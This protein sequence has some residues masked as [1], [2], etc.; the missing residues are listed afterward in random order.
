MRNAVGRLLCKSFFW[1]GVA[2]TSMVAFGRRF[3]TCC[4]ITDLQG[5]ENG[6]DE[7]GE[8]EAEETPH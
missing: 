7:V 3:L 4:V 8:E 2:L 1:G 5:A 6:R